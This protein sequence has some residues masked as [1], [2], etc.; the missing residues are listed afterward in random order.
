M[1]DSALGRRVGTE[2]CITG[3]GAKLSGP[4]PPEVVVGLLPEVFF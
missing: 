1:E 3:G 4:L 2:E